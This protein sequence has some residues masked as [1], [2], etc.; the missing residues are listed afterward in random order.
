MAMIERKVPQ[1]MINSLQAGRAFAALA[2]VCYHSL[3]SAEAFAGPALTLNAI[4]GYGYLGVDFFFVLSGFIIYHS[5]SGRGKSAAAYGESRI[6][7]IFLPY[8]PIGLAVALLYTLGIG[9][10]QHPWGWLA[11]LTLAPV[12]P[13]PAL[14]VAWTLQ[15]E[16]VFYVIFGL[17][18]FTNTLLVGCIF[19]AAAIVGLYLLGIDG[20]IPLSLLN[21][22]FMMGICTAILARRQWGPAWLYAVA[23]VPL[24]LWIALGASNAHSVLVGASLALLILPTVQMERAGR[25][26]VP[27]YMVFLGAASYAIYLIHNPVLSV[28]ARVMS[29]FGPESMIIVGFAASTAA[30]CA[31][32]VWIEKRLMRLPS[33]ERRKRRHKAALR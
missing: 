4:F 32:Y 18:Y 5:T 3:L 19:W 27:G 28:M 30:G 29:R 13:G 10:S 11:T 25:C 2:V 26:S 14:S 8:L 22:E 24:A 1:P 7:R 20:G 17:L 31:Y 33:F 12:L 15:H 16:M 23:V 9:G 21:L 6:R